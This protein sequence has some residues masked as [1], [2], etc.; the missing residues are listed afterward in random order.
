MCI[1]PPCAR[2]YAHQTGSRQ[3]GHFRCVVIAV[4]VQA[5]AAVEVVVEAAVLPV[6]VRAARSLHF[7]SRA[8]HQPCVRA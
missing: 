1:R 2:A 7:A 6:S 4:T 3:R 8:L 5:L